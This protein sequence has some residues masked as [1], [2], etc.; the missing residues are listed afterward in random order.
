MALDTEEAIE[1]VAPSDPPSPDFGTNQW[2]V[3]EMYDR[4]KAD[5]GS[6]DPTWQA[7]FA[8][9]GPDGSAPTN[10]APTPAETHDRLP[11]IL[12]NR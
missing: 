6:V 9:G 4:Y 1:P 11:P 10:G 8:K 5:P 7:F 3:E 12:V 2:L